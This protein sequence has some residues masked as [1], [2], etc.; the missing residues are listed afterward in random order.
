MQQSQNQKG[1]K[2]KKRRLRLLFGIVFAFLLWG[3]YAYVQQGDEIKA[4]KK[5]VAELQKQA[6]QLNGEKAELQ[7]QV[8]QLQDKDYV[9]ELARQEF[10]YTKKGEVLFITPEKKK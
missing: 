10:F 9:A 6:Q 3:T 7:K 2:G 1:L 5:K 4:S 8:Q